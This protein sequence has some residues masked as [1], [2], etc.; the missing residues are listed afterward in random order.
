LEANQDSNLTCFVHSNGTSLVRKNKKTEI[1][2]QILKEKIKINMLKENNKD[3]QQQFI[4]HEVRLERFIKQEIISRTKLEVLSCE[5][6]E[7]HV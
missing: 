4:N 6:Q 3:L 7:K 5:G 1:Y 2:E